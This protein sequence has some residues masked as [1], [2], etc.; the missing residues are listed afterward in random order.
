MRHGKIWFFLAA[1]LAGYLIIRDPASAA[2]MAGQAGTTL[3][4]A[5]DSFA[6]FITSL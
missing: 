1:I 3:S 6:T 2:D 4:N 5:A